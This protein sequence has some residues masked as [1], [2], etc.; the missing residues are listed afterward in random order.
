MNLYRLAC[1]LTLIASKNTHRCFKEKRERMT[2]F[3]EKRHTSRRPRASDSCRTI[4]E[5]S[6][7]REKNERGR[8]ARG[9]GVAAKHKKR[10]TAY[11]VGKGPLLGT[12]GRS[13]W[14]AEV[15][16]EAARERPIPG[17]NQG[18]WRRR[19]TSIG[20]RGVPTPRGFSASLQPA[21]TKRG[22]RGI[23]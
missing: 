1:T 19:P 7:L 23:R 4:W 21:G 2:G 3:T 11:P 18:H 14:L 5:T 20:T 12:I 13:G 9:T 15:R 16:G 6:I 10:D 8:K 17:M 22:T